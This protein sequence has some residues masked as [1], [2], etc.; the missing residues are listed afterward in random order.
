MYKHFFK[1]FIDIILSFLGII[2]LAIPMLIISLIIVITDPGPIWFKQKRVGMKKKG[3]ITYFS[4]L[5][6]RS[7]KMSTPHDV[8]THMLENPQ[9]YITSVGAILRKTS[10]D[11]L[12][13]LFNIL[14]GKM[15]VIGPRPALWNHPNRLILATEK[16]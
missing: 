13:Q 14:S 9:Q 11:E 5:K 12:L 3:E 15:S 2:V 10:G 16:S 1:R 8:P 6:F 7:M 4:L